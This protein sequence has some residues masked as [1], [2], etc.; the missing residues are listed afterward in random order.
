MLAGNFWISFKKWIKKN[1]YEC[2]NGD[3]TFYYKR[4]EGKLVGMIYAAR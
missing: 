4:V 2:M 1:G 3:S